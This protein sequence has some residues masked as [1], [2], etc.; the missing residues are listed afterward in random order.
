MKVAGKNYEIGHGDV[1]IA[2]ITSC[3]NTSNPSVMVA[4]GLVARNAR[5]RGIAPKPWVKTSLAPGSQVVT[6][7]LNKSG[8]QQDL[9]AIGFNTVGYGC[10]TCIGNSG[11]LDDEIANAIEDN[12]LVAVSVL[13]GN[14]NFEGRISPNV[15]ANYLASPPLVV[16]YALLGTM[17]EDI[18]T[19][20]LGT[21]KDGNP[22]YLKDVWPSNQEIAELVQSSLNREQFLRRYGEV[23]KGPPQWQAIQVDTGG[24]TYGWKDSS[25]YVKNPPY[26]EGITMDPKSVED[27]KGARILALLGDNITTDHISPAGAIRKNSPAGEY[28][29]ERHIG[30]KDFNS[31]GSRR[32][33][34]EVM[35]RGTF[36]NIRIRNEMTSGVEGG[37][38]RHYPSGEQ[39]PIY[40]AAKRYQQ[41]GVPLVVFAGKDTAWALRATGR[42]R[43][44]CCSVSGR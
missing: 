3:T 4:A 39:L 40:N 12:G 25:T 16:A 20:S 24:K 18:T 14:R 22:V 33:N 21:G 32:G 10:T 17:K 38:T 28:L 11:P 30:Q 19:A 27:I 35:M 23:F 7:Y 9:D 34:H 26:F 31:Y 13:S 42:R 36:A 43:A 44:R 1:V 41:Q 5:E 8:L 2:A 6:E 37:M 29:V 15:R